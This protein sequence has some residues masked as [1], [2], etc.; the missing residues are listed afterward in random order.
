MTTF[1]LAVSL[2]LMPFQA[3]V[4]PE[5]EQFKKAFNKAIEDGHVNKVCQSLKGR[6]EKVEGTE[7]F[8][9]CRPEKGVLQLSKGYVLVL[10]AYTNPQNRTGIITPDIYDCAGNRVFN[11]RQIHFASTGQ[12]ISDDPVALGGSWED[13]NPLSQ[14]GAILDAACRGAVSGVR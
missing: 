13:V 2:A 12:I 6:W 8:K 9:L 5:V 10:V 11:N 4:N 3:P 14:G 1:I 7:N